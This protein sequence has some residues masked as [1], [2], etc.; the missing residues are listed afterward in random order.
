[1]SFRR[2][3]VIC[4]VVSLPLFAAAD[5]VMLLGDTDAELQIQPALEAAGHV[6]TF[7]DLRPTRNPAWRNP[8][9]EVIGIARSVEK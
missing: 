5:N 6:V 1:M 9:E 4:T 2:V 7:A 3:L 8:A